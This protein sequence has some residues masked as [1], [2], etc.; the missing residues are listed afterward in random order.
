MK[1][2]AIVNITPDSF[3]NKSRVDSRTFLSQC[4]KFLEEGA[5]VLDIG[6][7]STRPQSNPVSAEEEW[8]R[9]NQSLSELKK[10]LGTDLFSK[11]VSI[12]TYKLET[13]K[14]A[15][16]MGVRIIND[17]SGGRD[18]NLLKTIAEFNSKI[19]LMHSIKTPK[20][21]QEDPQYSNV[22][23][24]V[25]NFL[26]TQSTLAETVGVSRQNIIWDF[27]IGFGKTLGHNLKLLSNIEFFKKSGYPLMA[28]VSR[29]SF[30]GNLLNIP[31]VDMRH[32]PTLVFHTYLACKH[33]DILRVHDVSDT[34]M[35][36]KI[37]QSLV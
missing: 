9:L 33:I 11:I 30:I 37:F 13:A 23:T 8:L 27:G 10:F 19:V 7:E 1:I 25:Y 5:D 6:A 12:D 32:D 16:E 3:Y 18:M 26:S 2:W 4:Q 36:R 14:K 28:G 22:V 17:V 31:N 15:L 34:S 35:I 20:I 24:E 29:K 21:M